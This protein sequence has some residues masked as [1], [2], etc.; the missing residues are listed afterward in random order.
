MTPLAAKMYTV[1]DNTRQTNLGICQI[2]FREGLTLWIGY[3]INKT[4]FHLHCPLVPIS[5]PAV[6]AIKQTSSVKTSKDLAMVMAA[7][8]QRGQSSETNHDEICLVSTTTIFVV[9]CLYLYLFSTS[10]NQAS[11]LIFVV[12]RLLSFRRF[13]S[14]SLMP[15]VIFVIHFGFHI[16]LI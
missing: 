10:I 4:F 15:L 7:Q 2:R 14:P 12:T 9:I 6:D 8:P 11:R 16:H 13:R 1:G 3:W 5:T